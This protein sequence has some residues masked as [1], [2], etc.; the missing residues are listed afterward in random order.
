MRL[1][2]VVPSQLMRG[3]LSQEEDNTIFEQV[4]FF[5]KIIKNN[6]NIFL[7]IR[8]N[9]SEISNSIIN[10]NIISNKE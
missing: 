5:P 10:T 7:A 2:C 1:Y 9:G 3:D 6:Y 4:Y 8:D